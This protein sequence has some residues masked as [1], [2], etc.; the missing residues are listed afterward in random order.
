ML[1][2]DGF[3]DGHVSA[4]I[5]EFHMAE[6]GKSVKEYFR[7]EPFRWRIINLANDDLIP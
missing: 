4:I 2:H 7:R 5:Y 6:R 3:T 1:R